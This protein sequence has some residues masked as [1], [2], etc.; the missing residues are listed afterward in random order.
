[1]LSGCFGGTVAGDAL[2][3]FPRT[4]DSSDPHRTSLGEA[5]VLGI[6]QLRSSRKWFGGI[7]GMSFDG[8]T[9]TAV[10]DAGH[11]LRFDLRLDGAGRPI[12]AENLEIFPLGGLDGSKEDGDAEDLTWTPQGWL[13][14]FERR[15]RLMLYPDGLSAK[16]VRQAAPEGFERQPN[17]G[18]TEA[19]ARLRDGRLM[20]LSEDGEDA[21][22]LGWGWIG[23]PGAWQRFT[24]RREGAFHPT[25]AVQLP[26]GDILVTER[27]FSMIGG[28]ALR[29]A[30][31]A[32]SDL[33]PGAVVRG[34]EV[35]RLE[36]PLL[37]DNFEGIAIHPRGDG[38]MVAYILSD[39]NFNPL[40]ATL[41]LSV[42]LP[43]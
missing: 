33:R 43:P 9:V 25:A 32:L 5:E 35:F 14:S 13:V 29:L 41:L 10:T 23:T 6:A 39:D 31:V 40:Q 26:D 27:R 8:R 37:V 15:H 2:E 11:W 36:P 28:V 24:Y 3:F 42:L 16:P 4:F 18:G 19:V 12:G 22:G 1:M 17:N 20:L 7:S 21:D 38:R 30:R 34:R